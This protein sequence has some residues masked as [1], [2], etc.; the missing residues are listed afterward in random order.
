MQFGYLFWICL[1]TGLLLVHYFT[2][3]LSSKHH[4]TVFGMTIVFAM[5]MTMLNMSTLTISILC[6][7]MPVI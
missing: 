7:V 2:V 4:L 3:L 6:P 1:D 5:T